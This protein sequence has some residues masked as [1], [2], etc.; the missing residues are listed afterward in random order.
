MGHSFYRSKVLIAALL[1]EMLALDPS[2]AADRSSEIRIELPTG[3]SPEVVKAISKLPGNQ[4]SRPSDSKWTTVFNG[5]AGD[6][7]SDVR[8]GKVQFGLIPTGA[9]TSVLPGFKVYDS[10]FVFDNLKDVDAFQK[11]T[12]GQKLLNLLEPSGLEG[13]SYLHDGLIQLA[14]KKTISAGTDLTGLS[15]SINASVDSFTAKQFEALGTYVKA[16]STRD[17]VA[18][19]KNGRSEATEIT[20]SDALRNWS[21]I[22][23][24][25][26][27]IVPTSHRYRGYVLVAN[28]EYLGTLDDVERRQLIADVR[29]AVKRQND[30]AEKDELKGQTLFSNGYGIFFGAVSKNLDVREKLASVWLKPRLDGGEGTDAW[31]SFAKLST[32]SSAEVAALLMQNY[33]ATVRAPADIKP[34]ASSTSR[35]TFWNAWV[36]EDGHVVGGLVGEH[37]Y[38]A[39]IDLASY[40]YKSM[41]GAVSSSALNDAVA[42][43]IRNHESLSLRV[44]AF[45]VTEG[46]EF[47]TDA[48]REVPVA[49]NLDVL[50]RSDNAIAREADL[51]RLHAMQKQG[52]DIAAF[53]E[54]FSAGKATF[55]ITSKKITTCVQIAFSIWN[56]VGTMPLDHVVL[57]M[58][59]KESEAVAFPTCNMPKVQ[60]SFGSL[61]GGFATSHPPDAALHLFQY[62]AGNGNPV[63]FAIYTDIA[64]YQSALPSASLADRGIY[65]WT[66]TTS[67]LADYVAN[68][69]PP[70]V[71]AAREKKNY[72]GVGTELRE[73]LFPYA[74]ADDSVGGA[75][76][77]ALALKELK[78]QGG[79]R[80]SLLVRAVSADGKHVYAPLAMLAASGDAPRMTVIYPLPRE[81]YAESVCVARWTVGLPKSLEGID[82]ED[83][84]VDE[85]KEFD[86][87]RMSRLTN[88]AELKSYLDPPPAKDANSPTAAAP[89]SGEAL[90]LLAH[91]ANGFLW[92]KGA[93]DD[94]ELRIP[95]E[96]NNRSFP[97]G[98]VAFL[99]ACN[100]VAPQR[101]NQALVERFNLNGVDAVIASPFPVVADYGR[102]LVLQTIRVVRDDYDKRVAMSIGDIFTKATDDLVATPGYDI[103]SDRSLEFV[104]LGDPS[105]KLCQPALK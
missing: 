55:Q 80:P 81:N 32:G 58:P 24:T 35:D 69:L 101:D 66:L 90:L 67:N 33:A 72:A 40:A 74:A 100:A 59:L 76:S 45:I 28:P 52:L 104:L 47:D 78:R 42:A 5:N 46:V 1:L 49:V 12:D 64:K 37:V 41:S 53:S 84:M 68:Q 26:Q 48:K 65:S 36:A 6:I 27:K 82:D 79:G 51:A 18:D 44:R 93:G 4:T 21:S 99:G 22:K 38:T 17:P 23:Q 88:L 70:A 29:Q 8:T 83:L 16:A 89:T 11:S 57:T 86:K 54:G 56:K 2:R 19:V 91:Q 97:P 50:R 73:K 60:G 25:G 39:T 3:T 85:S 103:S 95:L 13:V 14:S 62:V 102:L 98:S 61:A 63:T 105:L 77:A 20:W 87:T 71:A 10:L 7:L 94:A 43:S 92:F 96:A 9:L 31:Q 15:L 30:A 34:A 75:R